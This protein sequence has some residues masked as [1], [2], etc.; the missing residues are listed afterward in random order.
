MSIAV[1]YIRKLDFFINNVP[2][3]MYK[4][5]AEFGFEGFFTYDRL[6]LD[7]AKKHEKKPLPAGMRWGKKWEYGWFFTTITIPEECA[8]KRIIFSAHQ[9]ESV[10]FINNKVCGS[11]DREHSHITLCYCAKGGET[12]DIAIEAYAG[13]YGDDDLFLRDKVDLVIDGVEISEFADD[14]EQKTVS[15]GNFGIFYEDVFQLWM[16]V[17]TLYTLRK[18]LDEYSLRLASCVAACNLSVKDSISGARS[19]EESIK[20]DNL[21]ERREI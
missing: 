4:P 6:S 8:G 3:R 19:A 10:V 16:D 14:I 12:F 18:E 7:E 13:H 1:E 2:K 17:K 15:V 11:F 21:Y 20:L 9:G 5:V